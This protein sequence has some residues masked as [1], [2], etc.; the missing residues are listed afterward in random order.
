MSLSVGSRLLR[1]RKCGG[2]HYLGLRIPGNGKSSIET[3]N[4]TLTLLRLI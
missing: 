4:R 3:A 1:A 2:T